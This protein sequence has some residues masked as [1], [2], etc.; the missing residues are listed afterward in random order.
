MNLHRVLALGA[1]VLNAL[2]WLAIS[3]RVFSYPEN[4]WGLDNRVL[5]PW[6]GA[7]LVAAWVMRKALGRSALITFT[8]AALIS[9]IGAVAL[10]QWNVLVPYELWLKRGMPERGTLVGL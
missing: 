7:Q 1:L 10:L 5:I 3:F 8:A 9:L 4:H 2:I 6:F